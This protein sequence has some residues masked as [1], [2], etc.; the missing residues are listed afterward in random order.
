MAVCHSATEYG[1]VRYPTL[2]SDQLCDTIQRCQLVRG[3]GDPQ[4]YSRMALQHR[5]HPTCHRTRFRSWTQLPAEGIHGA[6]GAAIHPQV[7]RP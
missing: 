7:G 4:H 5:W 2:S 6:V 1:T 3:E